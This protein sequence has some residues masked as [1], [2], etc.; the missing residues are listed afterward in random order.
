[1]KKT[2]LYIIIAA[3]LASLTTGC[4]KDNN[5]FGM[6]LV[7]ENIHTT[8]KAAVDGISISWVNGESIRINGEN[9]TIAID[10]EGAYIT[11]VTESSIYRAIYP[12][13]INGSAALDGDNVTVTIPNTHLYN[14][15]ANGRQ[16][17]DIPMAGRSENGSSLYLK[18]LTAAIMV[19]ITNYYGFAVL[20]D[21]I[22]VRSSD[23]GTTYQLCGATTIDLTDANMG[24]SPN[25]SPTEAQK[26]V[27]MTFGDG[28]HALKIDQGATQ[29]VMVPV[30]PVGS[31]NRFSITVGVHK[32]G[33]TGVKKDYPK[34]QRTGGPLPRAKM[35]YANDT[36][37]FLFTVGVGRKVIIS[38]GNLQYQASTNTWRFAADQYDYIGNA[39]GNNTAAADRAEQSAWIDL[40]G[41]GTSGWNNGN[42]YY[43][44]YDIGTGG[45]NSGYGYGPTNGSVYNYSLIGVYSNSDWGVNNKIFNG[46]NIAGKWRTLTAGIGSETDTL[47][48][49][50]TTNTSDLP[51]GT[52]STNARYIKATVEG[53]KGFILFPDNYN[54]PNDVYVM[55][56]IV[57]NSLS[58]TN[59][60][61][62][63]SIGIENWNKMEAE[64]AVFLPAAGCRKN[65]SVTEGNASAYYWSSSSNDKQ[66]AKSIYFFDSNSGYGVSNSSTDNKINKYWG[67]SVRLVQDVR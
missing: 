59:Y 44:P 52:N 63:F 16:M 20:V 39:A 55:G 19:E 9:K 42:T 22:E 29:R 2:A 50:R 51:T 15:D 31:G 38:Q 21:S 54:H 43:Q 67:C 5:N 11:D 25:S 27:T 35:A 58:S 65:T 24:I 49:K 48:S 8:G 53:I 26:K 37:G 6:R 12:A 10:E 47:F 34:T 13:S 57:Y 18:H 17:L 1:M 66:T 41:W 45:S 56:S 60:F 40:F 30:L 23:E 36:V 64:G 62:G 61:N 3:T 7:G 46:G 32:D 14:S 33:N 4:H 28:A